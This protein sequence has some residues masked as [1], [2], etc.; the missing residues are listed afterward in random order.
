MA[1]THFLCLPLLT[2]T[3]LPQLEQSLGRL[4]SITKHGDC[5][6]PDSAF[7]PLGVLHLTLGV[8]SL[9]PPRLEAA[10]QLLQATDL[11]ALLRWAGD[12]PRTTLRAT[13]SAT[14]TNAPTTAS[15]VDAPS[16]SRTPQTPQT[17]HRRVSPLARNPSLP[18]LT[19]SLSGLSAFPDPRNATVLHASPH[20]P[21]HRLYHFC[22]ALRQNFLDAGFIQ[23]EER[24][25]VLHATLVNTVYSKSAGERN[26]ES[27]RGKGRITVDA[28]GV[29]RELNG[30]EGR[31]DERVRREDVGA[32]VWAEGVRIERVRICAMGAREVEGELGQEYRVVG[33][34]RFR[35]IEAGSV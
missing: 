26:R 13:I 22:L 24:P 7:R 17:P 20:D 11:D 32:F 1:P 14:G 27:G 33:E 16:R 25:L 12:R 30:R 35:V 9:T 19:V 29:M 15:D 4:R 6:I 2:P 8:M 5:K 28:R 21:T 3:S 31:E 18:R 34:K 23:P 10:L